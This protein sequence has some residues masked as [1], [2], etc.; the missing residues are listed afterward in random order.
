MLLRKAYDGEF[1]SIRSIS[2]SARSRSEQRITSYALA[3]KD[4]TLGFR[5]FAAEAAERPEPGGV[6]GERLAAER[7]VHRADEGDGV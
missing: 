2:A 5:G 1:G 4:V 3:R 6:D 7:Q